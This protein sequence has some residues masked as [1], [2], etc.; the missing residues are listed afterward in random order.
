MLKSRQEAGSRG[1]GCVRR[2]LL[3][4]CKAPMLECL[5][6]VEFFSPPEYPKGDDV[7]DHGCPKLYQFEP[8]ALAPVMP[9]AGAMEP[10]IS[11]E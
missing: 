8:L 6:K 2:E 5:W 3:S 7:E 4:D 9:E 10:S 1:C 11:L